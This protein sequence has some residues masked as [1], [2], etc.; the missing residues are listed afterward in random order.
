MTELLTSAQMRALEQAE[1]ESGAVTGLQLMERAGRGAVDAALDHWP[2]LSVGRHRA[3]ILCGPGN[4]GGDG[5]VIA[6]LLREQFWDVE[7]FFFGD[8]GKLPP[9]A[10]ANYDRWGR[11]GDVQPMDP[12]LAGQGA[13]PDLVVD[14]MFGTGLTR[15][16]PPDCAQ[17]WHAVGKRKGPGPLRR[18]AVDAP[19]GMDM[20]S[21]EYLHPDL[22]KGAGVEAFFAHMQSDVSPRLIRADLCVTFHRAKRGH[23]L[24]ELAG[25]R[26]VVVDIGLPFPRD[27]R[28]AARLMAPWGDRALVRLID[29]E[30]GAPCRVWLRHVAGIG[31]GGHKYQRGH[32][33]ILGGGPGKGGAA[34]MA[35]RAA[36]RV[37]A[38]LAT[39]AV[40]PAALQENAARLDAVMLHPLKG[41]DALGRLLQDARLSSVVLGPGLGV[42]ERTRDLVRTA[43]ERGGPERRVV[44]DADALTSFAEDPEALF[45]L[46]GPHV[47]LTPHE[48]EFARLFPDLGEKRRRK[49][50]ASPQ[51]SRIDAAQEAARRCGATVLLKGEATI[52]ASPDGTT[53]LHPALY[54]RRAPWLGTAGA[55]DVLAGMIGGILA[56]P[57]VEDV[58]RAAEAAAWLHVEAARSFGP[59]LI[60]E[61]LPDELPRVFRALGI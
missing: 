60:A 2:D 40:P 26:P 50:S 3:L 27:S 36:L 30:P 14:A 53:G 44:L 32:A 51:M 56:N 59:G 24:T 37:G 45:A 10:R 4:N 18:V 9:D 38:G 29:P 49:S 48:G 13:R 33:L 7:L 57:S 25:Q 41:D 61:D 22:A 20:D 43:L 8:P 17:A 1:I 28:D 16:I 55:G 11:L 21:G 47:V 19:S 5:F 23:Y 35:A 34:R 42:G 15:P 58:H 31:Q 52:I 12:A 6:R 54:D 46:C 39:I